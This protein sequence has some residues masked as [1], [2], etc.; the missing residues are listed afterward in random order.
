M[1][2]IRF[3]LRTLGCKVNQYEGD[4]IADGLLALGY[5]RVDFDDLADVYVINGCTVTGTANH[6]ARQLIRRARRS[7]EEALIV[8]TGCYADGAPDEIAGLLDGRSIISGNAGKG[9]LAAKVASALGIDAN[10]SSPDPSSIADF[11]S[12]GKKPR[13]DWVHSR[14]LVK[15]QDGCSSFC[16]YCIVPH[17]RGRLASKPLDEAVAEISALIEA[18]AP[19]VVLTGIHL[20]YYGADLEPR[21]RL[22]DI[23]LALPARLRSR[24]RGLSAARIRLS[25]IELHEITAQLIEL[26][27]EGRICSHFHIPLQSGSDRVL[28]AMNRRYTAEDFTRAC[29][30]I[31]ERLPGVALTTDVMVGFPGESDADFERTLTVVEEVGFSKVH[32]FRFSPRPGTPAA[33]MGNQ[34]TS[35]VKDGRLHRLVAVG[36]KLA[37]AYAERFVGSELEVVAEAFED[38][39]WT[40][41]SDNYL[42]VRFDGPAEIDAGSRLVRVQALETRGNVIY[43]RLV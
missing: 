42:R 40:G 3:A 9:E 21:R 12:T 29:R 31:Q 14:A 26:A 20:G 18:G 15:V 2:E 1:S 32:A 8:V 16:S 41:T 30:R 36:E 25:S 22:E 24:D 5:K 34:V 33:A 27:A 6:K 23:L 4:S 37:A 43:G 11:E 35:E 38:G 17:V 13:R 39:E 19:E 7:N 10:P 28:Q